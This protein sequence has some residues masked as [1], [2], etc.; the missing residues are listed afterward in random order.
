MTRMTGFL[1]SPAG[2]LIVTDAAGSGKS[3]LLARLVTLSDPD[4]VTDPRHEAMV[5]SIRP[6]LRPEPG[7]VDVAVLARNKSARTVVEDLLA[8]LSGEDVPRPE[9]T[10]QALIQLVSVRADRPAG[11]VTVVIDALDEAEDPLALVNDVILPLARLRIA[12]RRGAVRLV[13]GVRSSPVVL[14]YV[15]GADLRDERADQLLQRLTETLSTEGIAPQEIR[16]D[17][18]DCVGDIAAYAATLLLAPQDSPY[19]GAPEAATEAAQAI[20]AAVAPSFLDARIAADQL[21]R[22]ESRQDLTEDAWLDRLADGTTGLLREDI[23]AV[24][25]STDVPTDLLVAALRATA[26]APGAGL[27]WA[28]VWPAVTAALIA[29]EYGNAYAT[30]NVADHAIR[31]LRS[32]RLTGYLATADEDAR[33]VYRPVHQRLTD[34]LVTDHDWLLTPPSAT[35]SRWRRPTTGSRALVAAHAAIAKALAR[36]VRRSRPH[37]AH[38]YIRRHFLHHAAAGEVLTDRGVPL[39]LLTQET[40]GTLR[41]RLGLPLPTADLERRTLTAAA[42]TEPYLDDSVDF[43][44]RLSSIVFQK[45]GEPGPEDGPDRLPTT[46]VWSRWTPPT[47]V[48]APPFRRTAALCVLPT[49]DGRSL[50]AVATAEEDRVR[51]WDAATGELTADLNAGGGSYGLQTIRA[52]GGRTFLVVVGRTGVQIFDPTSGQILAAVSPASAVEVHVL[53]DDFALWK[54]FIRTHSGAFLW[55]PS[56][57]DVG[58]GKLAEASGFPPVPLS[59]GKTAVVRR[60]SGHALVAVAT[61]EGIRLW[62]PMAGLVARPPF[63]GTEA[64]RLM[65]V[66]RDE[67]DDLLLFTT[68]SR[69]WHVE[70][71]DPFAGK[72]VA[73]VPVTGRHASVALPG[74]REFAR[75][76]GSRIIVRDLDTG[77]ERSFDADVPTVD[78][79]AVSD[80]GANRRIISAGPQGVRVWDLDSEAEHAR[81]LGAKQYRS[82]W[83][84]PFR[85]DMWPLCRTHYPRNNTDAATDVLVVGGPEGLDVHDAATGKPLRHFGTGHIVAVQPLPSAPGTVLVAVTGRESWSIWDLASQRPVASMGGWQ[86][87]SAPSCIAMTSAGLSVFAVAEDLNRPRY[88]VWHSDSGIL[89]DSTIEPYWDIDSAS[90][91]VALPPNSHGGDRVVIAGGGRH[92]ITLIDLASGHRIGTLP[93]H[94]DLRFP[95]LRPQYLCTFTAQGRVLLAASTSATIHVWDTADGTPLATWASPDTLALTGLDLPDGRTLLASGDAGGVRIWD[96]WTGDLRHNLLTGAPVHALAAG[97]TPTDTVLHIHGPAG[98]ATVSVDERLL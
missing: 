91:L 78:A 42:I 70:V 41:A 71:W 98:L 43:T 97:T 50:I 45:G 3:A 33:T 14:P 48:L 37:P 62:D 56:P 95:D 44:S 11:P 17:G 22:A 28:E 6:E 81:R 8:A 73:Q 94:T 52:T 67:E 92:D 1:R 2:V 29:H 82:P 47:N 55:R 93:L 34:L 54:L 80:D 65:A 26:L 21:R 68:E 20:A 35:T 66:A 30:Y 64:H 84:T 53:E 15:T 25:L 77:N 46:P 12:D 36:L 18:H 76:V 57:Q 88:L 9:L 69:D 90:P 39:E 16:S 19:Q 79:L 51:I 4:F 23:K 59:D 86:L 83:A 40:S 49:M 85:R 58:S 27:P 10:L 31:T 63:V 74:G 75:T 32:S 72:Q 96:P 24:S 5:A 7:S 87:A 60:A 89:V 13:L 38:P 61:V